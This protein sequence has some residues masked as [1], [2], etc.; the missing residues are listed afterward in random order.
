MICEPF[1]TFGAK[2][3]PIL[4][5]DSHYHQMDRKEHPLETRHLGVPSSG[6]KTISEAMVRSVQTV[7]LSCTDNNTASK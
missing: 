4:H 2:R 5:Q 1:G 7:H 6:S 3:A